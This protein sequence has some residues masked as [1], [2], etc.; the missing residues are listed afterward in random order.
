MD[1]NN[2]KEAITFQEVKYRLKNMKLEEYSKQDV[3][4]RSIVYGS[5][6][7]IN[8]HTIQRLIIKH[9]N[10]TNVVLPE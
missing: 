10:S 8:N 3:F 6:E 9:G 1:I 2:P 5:E 7:K 4:E